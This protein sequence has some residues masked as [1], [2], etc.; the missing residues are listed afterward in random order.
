MLCLTA[1]LTAQNGLDFD[2]SNDHVQTNITTL[3]GSTSRTIEAWIKTAGTVTTQQIIVGMGTMPL[4]T[5]FTLNVLNSKLRIEIGG[6]GINSNANI[7][8]GQ[9][10]HVAVTYENGASNPFKLYIDGGLDA[11]GLS[12]IHI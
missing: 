4:G 12:L 10:H 9:W 7:D 3:T 2:G 6:G 8:D 11:Q 1:T 5:R